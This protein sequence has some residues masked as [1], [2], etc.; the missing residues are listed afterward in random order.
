MHRI[1]IVGPGKTATT[2]LASRLPGSSVLHDIGPS[3]FKFVRFAKKFF[4]FLKLMIWQHII[5]LPFRADDKRRV[6]MF[7]NDFELALMHFKT[8]G[9]NYKIKRYESICEFL[10]ACYENYPYESY[11]NWYRRNNLGI[12]SKL[13]DSRNVRTQFFKSH[14][15]MCSI[16]KF[17]DLLA[18]LAG[19]ITVTS[20]N[21]QMNTKDEFWHQALHKFVKEG[22]HERE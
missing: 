17:D 19:T 14:V 13:T 22:E 9:Q 20:E 3:H 18:E 7:W 8:E 12:L 16:E 15:I 4:F 10:Q 5:I 2:Y 1:I 6:S 21:L 11:Q